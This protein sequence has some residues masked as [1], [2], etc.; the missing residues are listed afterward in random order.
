MSTGRA[1]P[2]P[3]V[4]PDHRPL[5]VA[6]VAEDD[7]RRRRLAAIVR[8]TGFDSAGT[9]AR[10]ETLAQ[11]GNGKR[12]GAIVAAAERLG[13]AELEWIASV[14]ECL[15]N[16]RLVVVSGTTSKNAVR[17]LLDR[18]ADGV[19]LE[20]EASRTLGPTIDAVCAGQL[21]LPHAFRGAVGRPTLSAREKQVLAMVVMGF[22]NAEIAT[23]LF[24]AESTVK[25]HLSSA[26]SRLGVRS[27]R[28]ATAV[29]LDPQGGLG[30]GILS[31]SDG[32]DDGSVG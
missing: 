10:P 31:L 32:D 20:S 19:V 4:G 9:A 28:E 14:R 27:R 30:M 2:S 6:V 11:A 25:S 1:N 23:K 16:S 18:G 3:A 22:S 8:R 15:P 5:A 13:R 12:P 7:V 24:V 26:F 29:I 17:A 21:V